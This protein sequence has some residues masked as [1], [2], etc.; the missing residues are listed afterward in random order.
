MT[1]P[2]P[3]SL[4]PLR[5][6]WILLITRRD[7]IRFLY[8]PPQHPAG[9]RQIKMYDRQGYDVGQLVWMVCDEC[10]VGSI[11][12][13]SIIDPFQR[14]GLGRRLIRRAVAD[15]PDFRWRTTV[16]SAKAKEFFPVVERETSIAFPECDSICEHLRHRART[17]G[18]AKRPAAV[19]DR[20]V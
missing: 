14:R 1:P 5:W 17:G 11:N 2:I 9:L 6:R 19:L 15:G 8:R 20:N 4:S 18:A 3:G 7:E 10:R 12:K 16:Q 13:I